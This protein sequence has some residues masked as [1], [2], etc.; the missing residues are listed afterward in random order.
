MNTPYRVLP[1]YRNLR[2]ALIGILLL[3]A[4][5]ANVDPK[6]GRV[7]ENPTLGNR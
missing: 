7:T 2:F 1:C 6:K 4:A 5:H 3:G